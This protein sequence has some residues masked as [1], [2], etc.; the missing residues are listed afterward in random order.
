V[1]VNIS[2]RHLLDAGFPD[3]LALVLQ[4]HPNVK[5]SDL[6]L[7]ILES[8][9]INDMKL[10]EKILHDCGALGVQFSLDDFGTGYSSLTHLRK[11]PVHT[12]KIDQ[13]FV[14]NMLTDPEDLGIVR[15]V[16]DLANAFQRRV[17]AEGVE[18]M[19]LG[20]ALVGMGCRFA[21][22]YGIARPMPPQDLPGWCRS[23]KAGRSWQVEGARQEA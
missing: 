10:A 18:T 16:I 6:E 11:L 22:G 2:A 1:S 19:T 12:L 17:I 14:R 3:G 13:S 20:H 15:G 7:E 8:A 21:Q 9:A 4:R 23:W 5:P